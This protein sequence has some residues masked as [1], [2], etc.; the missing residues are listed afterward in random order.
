VLLGADLESLPPLPPAAV[1]WI[2]GA[3]LAL[4]LLLRVWILR[5][6]LRERSPGDAGPAAWAPL[7][8]LAKHPLSLPGL[9]LLVLGLAAVA[10]MAWR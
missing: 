7:L 8:A 4:W 2:L 9:L 3:L 6:Q 1:P 5:G 10:W